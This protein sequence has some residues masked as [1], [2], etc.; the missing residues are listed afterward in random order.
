MVP[1][2]TPPF[3]SL[4]DGQ[5]LQEKSMLA[6]R[7]HQMLAVLRIV[8]ALVFMEHGCQKLL[9]FPSA[10]TAG[11]PAMLT[12]EW[13]AGCMELF[14]GLLVLVGFQTRIA[15]FL[16]SGEMAIGYFLVHAPKSFFPAKNGGEAAILFCFIFLYLASAGSGTWAID[17]RRC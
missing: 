15:A 14:G 5:A 12:L 16:M 9:G 2:G 8:T 7:S 17:N 4:S 6:G 11:L 1:A 10:P 3:R 13:F